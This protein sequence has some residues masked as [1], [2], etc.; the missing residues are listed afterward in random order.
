MSRIVR[1]IVQRLDLRESREVY[2]NDAER[3]SEE[4]RHAAR[5][6]RRRRARFRVDDL[7]GR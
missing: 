4:R 5:G 6:R 2:E 3:R 7:R 1:A